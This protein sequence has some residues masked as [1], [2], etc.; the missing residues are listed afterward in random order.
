MYQLSTIVL[1][2]TTKITFVAILYPLPA[3]EMAAKPFTD[4]Q[5]FAGVSRSLN[6]TFG[7]VSVI[8]VIP[9][10]APQS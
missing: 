4:N 9:T 2:T 3:I 7:V 8:H 10:K 1:S 6:V 5:T